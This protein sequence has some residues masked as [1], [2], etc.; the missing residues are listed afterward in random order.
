M[1]TLVIKS[2][3]CLTVNLSKEPNFV[4]T[5][6]LKI[7]RPSMHTNFIGKFFQ[8]N[9]HFYYTVMILEPDITF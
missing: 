5:F 2:E 8:K 9:L 7:L 4:L 6:L 3:K 1:L